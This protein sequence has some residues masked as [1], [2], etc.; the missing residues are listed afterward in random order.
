VA[1]MSSNSPPSSSR[2]LLKK[3]LDTKIEWPESSNSY[4]IPVD[5]LE[6]IVTEANVDLELRRIFRG[7]DRKIDTFRYASIVCSND[8][9]AKKVF[10]ILLATN[11]LERFLGEFL[12]EGITDEDL[13][14]VRHPKTPP[15]QPSKRRSF[16]LCR[17]NHENCDALDHST[18]GINSMAGWATSD[19]QELCRQQ[20]LVQACVFLKEA[21]KIPQLDIGPGVLLPFTEDRENEVVKSGGFS[22]VWAVK[23]HPAHQ[24][25]YKP[26][27]S[28]VRIAI[29]RNSN[30]LLTI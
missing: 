20:W 29:F 23:I 26:P 14:F 24:D 3:I 27:N 28:K 11:D 8:K 9:K 17:A 18:C 5:S 16:I 22:E 13:P 10:V 21:G 7:T 6:K 2:P 12:D 19:I 1:R 25:V 30:L 4:F 15:S